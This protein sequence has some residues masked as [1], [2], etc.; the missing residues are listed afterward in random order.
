MDLWCVF[1]TRV[2]VEAAD[3]RKEAGLRARCHRHGLGAGDDGRF[4][5]RVVKLLVA[6]RVAGEAG[7]CRD[8]RDPPT[9]EREVDD[10]VMDGRQEGRPLR[11]ARLGVRLA[12]DVGYVRRKLSR[13]E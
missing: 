9:E 1:L 5:D 8:G 6:R 3:R 4:V 13:M 7:T 2:W 10:L 12:E 11:L